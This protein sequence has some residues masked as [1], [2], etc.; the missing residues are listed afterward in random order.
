[1]KL[2][3]LDPTTIDRI[4]EMA[5]ED[6]TPFEAIELQF[7]LSEKDVI[8][9]MRR[10]MKESSFKMWRERVTKRKTKHLHKRDFVAGRFKS[11]NQKT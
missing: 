9:L 10:E 4:V 7:G 6:R 11:D 1:M 5:W 8:S 2:P 3:E